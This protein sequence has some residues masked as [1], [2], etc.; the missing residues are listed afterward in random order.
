MLDRDAQSYYQELD[1]KRKQVEAGEL[2]AEEWV[3]N[4]ICI[5][6]EVESTGAGKKRKYSQRLSFQERGK[7]Q[8][9]QRCQEGGAGSDQLGIAIS[10]CSRSPAPSDRVDGLVGP[11]ERFLHDRICLGWEE[12]GG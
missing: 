8:P 11:V 2:F 1:W 6:G 12:G 3:E 7:R 9:G 10:E 4:H 5:L